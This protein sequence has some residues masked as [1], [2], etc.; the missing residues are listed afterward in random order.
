MDPRIFGVETEEVRFPCHWFIDG[1]TYP[2]WTVELEKS[3]NNFT[4]RFKPL[5]HYELLDPNFLI[6]LCFDFRVPFTSKSYHQGIILFYHGQDKWPL[7]FQQ[8]TKEIE[9]DD[10]RYVPSQGGLYWILF[11]I[12]LLLLN[13]TAWGDTSSLHKFIILLCIYIYNFF[14]FKKER[15]PSKEIQKNYCKKAITSMHPTN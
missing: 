8:S 6:L 4:W 2:W 11:P 13:R 5:N 7:F 14:F 1:F 9:S 3:N 15:F 12:L 10:T